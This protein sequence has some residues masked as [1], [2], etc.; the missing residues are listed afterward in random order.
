MNNVV[1]PRDPISSY[2]INVQ[3]SITTP[4]IAQQ[5]SLTNRQA[6]KKIADYLDATTAYLRKRRLTNR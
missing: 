2:V 5:S 6:I 3:A 1:V 4:V